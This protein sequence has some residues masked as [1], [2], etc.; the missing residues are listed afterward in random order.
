MQL[1]DNYRDGF[2]YSVRQKQQVATPISEFGF[3]SSA[4]TT[5][6]QENR[7]NYSDP[8]PSSFAL[9]LCKPERIHR[10]VI[11]FSG[12]FV[13]FLQHV[14]ISRERRLLLIKHEVVAPEASNR[15]SFDI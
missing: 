9:W 15:I 2:V 1:A 6:T 11:F 10:E 3:F 8:L 5:W 7:Q 13:V 14:H 12:Q 4:M